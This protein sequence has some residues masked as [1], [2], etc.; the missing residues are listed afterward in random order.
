MPSRTLLFRILSWATRAGLDRPTGKMG[1]AAY[2]SAPLA[3][4]AGLGRGGEFRDWG[5]GS[6][7]YFCEIPQGALT[8]AIAVDFTQPGHRDDPQGNNVPRGF[9]YPIRSEW[10]SSIQNGLPRLVECGC[11]YADLFGIEH[12]GMGVYL[13]KTVRPPGRE[14]SCRHRAILTGRGRIPAFHCWTRAVLIA[15]APTASTTEVLLP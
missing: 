2:G 13:D 8:E 12:A 14:L 1:A 11:N 10:G 15:P 9:R 5:C 4:S 3:R 7:V 6:L